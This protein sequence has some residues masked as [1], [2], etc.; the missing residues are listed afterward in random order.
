MKKWDLE[1][2]KLKPEN[3]TKGISTSQSLNSQE[4]EQSRQDVKSDR[5]F[6]TRHPSNCGASSGRTKSWT[7]T[8][9]F[10][11]QICHDYEAICNFADTFPTHFWVPPCNLR[12]NRLK[13]RSEAISDKKAPSEPVKV[14]LGPKWAP[15]SNSRLPLNL[16]WLLGSQPMLLKILI[17][18]LRPSWLGSWFFEIVHFRQGLVWGKV[19]A[20]KFSYET[21]FLWS[22]TLSKLHP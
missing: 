16:G 5:L 19:Q 17:S 15:L 7:V 14:P 10:C 8:I 12:P 2:K 20:K 11:L 9:W 13:C 6:Q 3:R 21:F 22:S 4:P 18:S 1:T